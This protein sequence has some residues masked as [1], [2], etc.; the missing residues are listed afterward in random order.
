M[1]GG[2]EPSRYGPEFHCVSVSRD[3]F[4][5]RSHYVNLK[6]IGGGSYGIVCSAED[7]VIHFFSFF[8]FHFFF[9]F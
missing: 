6:P 4:E 5:V 7:T 1:S 3:I 2:I 8:I 9:F